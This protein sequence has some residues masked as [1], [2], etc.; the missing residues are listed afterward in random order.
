[1][2][3][4]R[5]TFTG[6]WRIIGSDSFRRDDLDLVGPAH[7]TLRRGGHGELELIALSADVDYR[8]VAR[9]GKPGIEFSW[10]GVDEGD[11]LSGRGWAVLEG[12]ELTGRILIHTGDDF[13]FVA[14][15]ARGA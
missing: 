11:R 9:D 4:R 14:C 6:R 7:L 15:R 1:M 5:P 12:R 10:E 3:S 13:G 8:V 2:P